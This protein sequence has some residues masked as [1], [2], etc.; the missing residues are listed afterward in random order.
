MRLASIIAVALVVA[1]SPSAVSAQPADMLGK[2][3]VDGALPAGTV[4]V[5]VI[6]GDF[7]KPVA[8]EVTVVVNGVSRVARTDAE[9]RATF[10]GLAVGGQAQ[11]KI[12]GEDD[13]EIT[14]DQFVIASSGGVRLML[15]TKPM[16]ASAMGMGMGGAP[17]MPEPRRI[18]GTGRPDSADPPGMLTVRLT[19][20]D[21]SDQAPDRHPVIVVG[22]TDEN[23]VTIAKA[24]TDAAGRAEFKGL[25]TTG[26]TAYFAMTLMPRG[27]TIDR[28]VSQ[29][30]QLLP[31]LGTRMVL[32]AAKRTSNEPAIDDYSQLVPSY[33]GVDPGRVVA[34]VQTPE[35]DQG[36]T[37]ELVQVGSSEVLA[38]QP[39]AP[40]EEP[41]SSVSSKFTPPQ[42][43]PRVPAGMIAV[44]ALAGNGQALDGAVLDLIPA[45]G[46]TAKPMKTQSQQD[47][48]AGFKDV[49]AGKYTLKI[50]VGDRTGTSDPFDITG[51]AANGVLIQALLAWYDGIPSREVL[52]QNVPPVTEPVYVRLR[53]KNET[54]NGAP[55][56]ISPSSG[57]FERFYLGDRIIMAFTL[58]GSVDDKYY[59]VN[60]DITLYNTWWAPYRAGEDGLLVRLPHGFTGG[61]VGDDDKQKVA[62]DPGY[63]LRIRRPIA[64][65]GMQF[66]AGFS[67]PIVDGVATWNMDLPYGAE[68]STIN[69]LDAPGMKVDFPDGA[70]SRYRQGQNGS[71][72]LSISG[73]DIASGHSLQMT[74]RGLPVPPAWK[75]WTPRIVGLLVL[76]LL[77]ATVMLTVRARA[78]PAGLRAAASA[79]IQSLMDELVELEQKGQG[80]RRKDQ[81]LA[82]LEKL[83]DADARTERAV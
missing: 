44:V 30:T 76:V 18:S 80:G 28:L 46:N 48:F 69:L 12:T 10:Q 39:L 73:I 66:Q 2:T 19:Y 74:I 49:A 64:P 14:S 72:W 24:L 57:Y 4:I 42:T 33:P 5:R 6:A 55:F 11:A 75:T 29:P 61:V 3:R 45:E 70:T 78:Q 34:Q 21:F 37:I 53:L 59:A 54:R 51:G 9:G 43:N 71:L 56:L 1:A 22:Y 62:P 8:T 67:L 58:H 17:G 15:S 81:I 77:V 79:K 82:E 20:D 35:P 83:W 50:S 36:G 27:N 23:K 63:G 13:K 25:D 31:G 40:S 68:S 16:T 47:G 26:R 32:S 41:S 7:T 38:S 52:F 60:G 65:G